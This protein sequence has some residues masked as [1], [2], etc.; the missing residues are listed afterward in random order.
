MRCAGPRRTGRAAPV[1]AAGS[2]IA[3]STRTSTGSRRRVPATRSG[4]GSATDP[5]PGTVRRLI[6]GS[7][8]APGRGRRP[9]RHPRAGR[10]P[11]RRR[12]DGPAQDARGA[13]GRRDDR[14]LRRRR[15]AAPADGPLALHPDP[16][17]AGRDPRD[18]G[19]P[20]DDGV[21]EPP[22]GRPPRSPV[23]GRP[24]RAA[25]GRSPR[26]RSRPGTRLRERSSTCCRPGRRAPRGRPR[27]DRTGGGPGRALDRR[28]PPAERPAARGGASARGGPARPR[29]QP[30]RAGPKPGARRGVPTPVDEAD[31]ERRPSAD[32]GS[33]AERRR[34]AAALV[35]LWRDLVRDLAR[36]ARRRT[37]RPRSGAARRPARAAADL[38]AAATRGVPGPAR[39]AGELLEANIEPRDRARQPP[40]RLAAAAS[41]TEPTRRPEW[42]NC[43]GSRRPSA[44]ASRASASATSS[45]ARRAGSAWPAG[46]RTSRTAASDASRRGPDELDRLED[47]PRTGPPGAVV[48]RRSGGRMPA[49]GRFDGFE[50]RSGGHSG[51]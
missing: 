31:D 38:T 33:A 21:A 13:A 20:A 4:S 24:G 44:V 46:S 23:G 16:A 2:S 25:I 15:G 51:D 37:P 49:T 26:R 42:T 32:S 22:L 5:E 9:R 7:R 12:P 47:A 50:V 48:E 28:A 40:A 45:F 30:S 27:P 3:A 35:A 14:A 41:A 1:A 8:P 29:P 18:R 17:R 10:P 11:E 43:A 36:P 34:A 6:V 39:P 19:D